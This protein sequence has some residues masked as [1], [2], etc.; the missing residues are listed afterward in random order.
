MLVDKCM[1]LAN[2]TR[3]T[4]KDQAMGKSGHLWRKRG[5]DEGWRGRVRK[6]GKGEEEERKEAERE[7]SKA[8]S[9]RKL[10]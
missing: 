10:L 6:R 7:V 5:G 1:G 4:N 3:V 2:G 9:S 8:S